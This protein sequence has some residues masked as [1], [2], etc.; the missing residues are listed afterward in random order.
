MDNNP[1]D[2]LL[3]MQ[4][5]IE[6]NRKYYDE[7]MKKLTKYLTAM[8]TSIMD[9]IKTSKYSPDK[10]DSPK[11]QDPTTVVLDNNMDIPFGRW[12]F[13]KNGGM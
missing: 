2:Q 3:T 5:T 9:H 13:Y 4:A 12:I 6:A 8:I 7:K 11:A 1:D 10:K